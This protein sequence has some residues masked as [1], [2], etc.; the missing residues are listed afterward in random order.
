MRFKLDENLPL[1]AA[2]PLTAAGHEV[3]TAIGED[4]A[5][6]GDATLLDRC[7]QEDRVLVT[8][9]LHLA[10]IR[11]YPPREHRGVVVLRLARQSTPRIV[12]ALQRLVEAL[13]TALAGQLCVVDEGSIRLHD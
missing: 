5:G 8:L 7:G 2:A 4:L 6:A 3:E 1:E 10:N 11:R 9:D 12:A 13:P